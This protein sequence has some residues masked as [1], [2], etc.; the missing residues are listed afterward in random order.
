MSCRLA[1]VQAVPNSAHRM[2]Q[3]RWFCVDLPTQERDVRLDNRRLTIE[4]VTPHVIEDL[5]PSH[6]VTG[7]AHQKPEQLVLGQGE[8]ND[9]SPRD[10]WCASLSRMRSRQTRSWDSVDFPERR[11]IASTLATSSSTL[12]G[13]V[14]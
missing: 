5:R 10:T 9:F 13:L 2:D 6:H 11:R 3:M 4:V 1:G 7:I 14:R 8:L 12:K